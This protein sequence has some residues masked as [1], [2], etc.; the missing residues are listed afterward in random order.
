VL[1]ARCIAPWCSYKTQQQQ[2]IKSN[3]SDKDL[4]GLEWNAVDTGIPLLAMLSPFD[5]EI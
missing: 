5:L 2:A 3:V 4:R 1:T